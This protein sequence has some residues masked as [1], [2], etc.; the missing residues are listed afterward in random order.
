MFRFLYAVSYTH[1]DV[2]KRQCVICAKML[3]NA[4]I[5][6]IVH[7]GEYP[8]ELSRKILEEA[9]IEVVKMD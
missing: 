2:Y 1:L 6:R 3:I 4:G 5:K 9:D 8:D 7:K